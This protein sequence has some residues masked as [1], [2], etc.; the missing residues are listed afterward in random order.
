VLQPIIMRLW[1]KGAS[2]VVRV[3]ANGEP[4]LAGTAQKDCHLAI[5]EQQDGIGV[6]IVVDEYA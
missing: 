4:F 5:I 1:V 6:S 2:Q 3:V